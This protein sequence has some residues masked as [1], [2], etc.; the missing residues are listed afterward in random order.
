MSRIQDSSGKTTL[1]QQLVQYLQDNQ[2][3]MKVSLLNDESLLVNRNEAY[4]D[5]KAEKNTRGMI[6][7]AVER[8]LSKQCIVVCDSLNYIKGYRYELYCIARAVGTPSCVVW[9]H[10]ERDQTRQFN[11][12]NQNESAKW[13]TTI[14]DE[15][16]MR[17]EEPNSSR[18]WEKPTYSVLNGELPFEDIFALVTSKYTSAINAATQQQKL[19]D[20]NYL[21]RLDVVTQELIKAI[22]E[23]QEEISLGNPIKVPNSNRTVNCSRKLTVAE[24]RRLRKQYVKFVG[25]LVQTKASFGNQTTEEIATAFID[26]LNTQIAAQ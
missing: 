8:D 5:S 25:A 20:T 21:H 1:A 26:F 4:K 9:V 10:T 23:R 22:L 3:E 12:E 17:F 18:R 13:N 24:L 11:E 15:L 7:A 19:S 16:M 2:N 6:K 14:L